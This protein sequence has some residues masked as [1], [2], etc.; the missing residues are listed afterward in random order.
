MSVHDFFAS[1]IQRIINNLVTNKVIEKIGFMNE[2]D[3]LDDI[4]FYHRVI[5]AGFKSCYI[6]DILARQPQVEEHAPY[7]E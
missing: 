7:T 2:A 3:A 6:P 1:V 5:G 4:D